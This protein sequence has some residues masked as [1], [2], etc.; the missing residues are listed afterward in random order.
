MNRHRIST[1][2]FAWAGLA[3]CLMFSG[4]GPAGSGEKSKESGSGLTKVRFQTDWYPQA[5]HGGYYQ[6]LV[7]GYYREVG[8][9]VE[10]IPGG[11]GAFVGQKVA[12]GQAEFGMGRSD[13]HMLAVAEGIPLVMVSALMQR[14]PQALLLH[15]ENPVKSFADLDGR[16]IM[17]VPG[18]AWI[19]YVEARYKVKLN[20]I[21]INY[22]LAQFMSDKNF[23]QQCFVTNEPY[24]VAQAG[25]KPRTLLLASS[26]YDPYRIIFTNQKF[27]REKPEIVRAFVAAS[28]RG[29]DDFLTGDATAAKKMIGERN[30]KM[31]DEFME[32]TI[33]SLRESQLISGRPEN[34]ERTGLLTRKRLEEQLA[35][36]VELKLLSTPISLD[37]AVSFDFLPPELQVLAKAR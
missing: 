5:E 35:L 26:G 17:A 13:D 25:R 24:Y 23:I 29:W 12:T 10:I 19:S 27:T 14:D 36:L 33:R 18:A 15:D 2:R 6:A 3:L 22:G 8:L 9:D 34:G 32:F 16:T 28:I 31:S 7:K 4:C 37:K 21:P 20:I 30:E 1:V 11:P